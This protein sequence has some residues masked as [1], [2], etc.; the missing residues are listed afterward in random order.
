MPQRTY[1]NVIQETA[2]SLVQLPYSFA[3]FQ[4]NS[5]GK[6]N[7]FLEHHFC[8]RKKRQKE[9][10]TRQSLQYIFMVW[11]TI[12]MVHVIKYKT[13]F[14]LPPGYHLHSPSI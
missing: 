6:R 11:N 13:N 1:I 2:F 12:Y 5:P 10:T 9:D 8:V 7:N 14:N 3:M 4:P